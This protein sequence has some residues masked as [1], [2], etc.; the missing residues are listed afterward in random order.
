MQTGRQSQNSLARA[1]PA[2]RLMNA[3][4]S[5]SGVDAAVLSGVALGSAAASAL[6]A[7]LLPLLLRRCRLDRRAAQ[8]ERDLLAVEEA[9]IA[10]R[11]L[12]HPMALLPFSDFKKA[13]QLRQHEEMRARLVFIDTYEQLLPFSRAN[14]SVFFSHQWFCGRVDTAPCPEEP[15]SAAPKPHPPSFHHSGLHCVR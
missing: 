4:D 11:T 2:A 10:V 3:T 7:L 1:Q 9:V 15:R 6:L 12:K 13:G 14:P 5:C 8:R